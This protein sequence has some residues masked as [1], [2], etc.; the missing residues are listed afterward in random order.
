M[1][2]LIAYTRRLFDEGRPLA[3][4][5]RPELRVDVEMFSRGGLAVLSAIEA[6]GYDT[7]HRRPA[8][9]RGQQARLLGRA[10]VSRL[11]SAFQSREEPAGVAGRNA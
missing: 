9:S 6:I 7:L 3:A 8:I 2:D 4:M 1:K 10:L 5:I 11:F